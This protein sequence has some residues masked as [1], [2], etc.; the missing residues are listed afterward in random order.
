LSG[1]NSGHGGGD[2]I[3]RNV[4]VDEEEGVDWDLLVE[5][6]HYKKFAVH[7]L[8]RAAQADAKKHGISPG[9]TILVTKLKGERGE[10]VTLDADTFYREV[11]PLWKPQLIKRK[12]QSVATS[13]KSSP[14]FVDDCGSSVGSGEPSDAP[15]KAPRPP[16][17][18]ITRPPKA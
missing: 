14:A 7:T 17:K 6:K 1:E 18:K 5:C 3:L 10:L 2:I 12:G 8:F 13:G 15:V 16:R 9:H 4:T 11:L